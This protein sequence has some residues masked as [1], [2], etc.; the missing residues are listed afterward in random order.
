VGPDRVYTARSSGGA[1]LAL[2]RRTGEPVWQAETGGLVFSSP[3]LADGVVYVGSGDGA[4]YAFDAETGD[5]RWRYRTEGGVM[6]TP[7]LW[8][9]HLVIGS[10]DGSVYALRPG[11]RTPDR[12]VYWDDDFAEGSLWGGQEDHRRTADYFRARG[13]DGIDGPGLVDFLRGTGDG[14]GPSVLQAVLLAGRYVLLGIVLYAMVLMPGVGPV[15]V[16]VGLSVLVLALLLEAFIQLSA[17][18]SR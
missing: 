15:P 5:V 11:A 7:V 1:V 9:E 8:N 3:L 16:A 2:N 10:E 18:A 14:E 12:A 4:I 17:G 6:S 13:Y